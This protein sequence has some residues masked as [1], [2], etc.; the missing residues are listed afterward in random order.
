M[1]LYKYVSLEA[2][3]A[4][5][6]TNSLGFTCLSEFNDP[7][8]RVIAPPVPASNGELDFQFARELRG[9]MK[10][11]IY[12]SNYGALSLTRSPKNKLMWAHYADEHRGAVIEIDVSVAGFNCE[13][14]NFIPS[15]LGGVIYSSVP[16]FERYSSNFASTMTLGRTHSFHIDHYEKKQR[17]FLTKPLDWAYEEEVR[18]VKCLE[19]KEMEEFSN[20]S[21]EFSKIELDGNKNTYCLK[22]REGSIISVILGHRAVGQIERVRNACPK[23]VTPLIAKVSQDTFD[24]NVLKIDSSGTMTP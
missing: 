14:T 19:N 16:A 6:E 4:I 7:F 13:K 8:D 18:V 24:I 23:G 15:F 21:G 2:L 11:F 3:M 1:R 9:Q 12:D 17:L 20:K 22:L 5:L 10:S